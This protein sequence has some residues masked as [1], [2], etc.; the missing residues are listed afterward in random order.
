MHQR[1][2]SKLGADHDA[3]VASD[4][5]GVPV[6]TGGMNSTLRDACRFGQMIRDRG[7]FGEEQVVPAQWVDA[8]LKVDSHTRAKM[9]NN[10]KYKDTPWV[11]YQNMWWILDTEKGEYAANGI[12]GQFIYVNR[13]RD[14]VVTMFSHHPVASNATSEDTTVKLAAIR[15][16]VKSDLLD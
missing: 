6:A 7:R 11:A 5:A 12:H 15:E 1:I 10:P 3:Y 4:R 14:V 13:S 8:T 9:T 2:W 16:L